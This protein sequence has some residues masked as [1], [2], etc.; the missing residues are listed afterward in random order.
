MSSQYYMML[1]GM[2]QKS[3]AKIP[4]ALLLQCTL[5][6]PSTP[7]T[8]CTFTHDFWYAPALWLPL[9]SFPALLHF[10]LSRLP[11]PSP[12]VLSSSLLGVNECSKGL[13]PRSDLVKKIPSLSSPLISLASSSCLIHH[14]ITTDVA[15]FVACTFRYVLCAI[16]KA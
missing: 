15:S 16:T 10:P 8:L 1:Y 13:G 4:M 6:R 3:P 12:Q 11:L 7:T 2:L 14:F 9:T 5:L